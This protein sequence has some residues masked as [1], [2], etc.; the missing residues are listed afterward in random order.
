MERYC[1]YNTNNCSLFY[2]NYVSKANSLSHQHMYNLKN[3]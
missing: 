1:Y 2:L 3:M